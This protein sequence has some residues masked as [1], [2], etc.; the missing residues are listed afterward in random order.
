MAEKAISSKM[1]IMDI[2]VHDSISLYRQY[3]RVVHGGT[4]QTALVG[5]Q[6]DADGRWSFSYGIFRKHPVYF[7]GICRPVYFIGS[8]VLDAGI[9]NH[10]EGSRNSFSIIIIAYGNVLVY[11]FGLYVGHVR[12]AGWI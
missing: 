7:I 9:E 1:G 5:I 4:G 12:G 2:D 3:G 6:P 10:Q 11:H 8:V